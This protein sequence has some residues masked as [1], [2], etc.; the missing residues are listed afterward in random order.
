MT[1]D[2]PPWMG[3]VTAPFIPSL[4]EVQHHGAGDREVD[5]LVAA[6]A[7]TPDNP[8]RGDIKVCELLSCRC[9]LY[10]FVATSI[11]SE[12]FYFG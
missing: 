3:T 10:V 9:F 4:L 5:L 2:R 8:Q 11:F 1:A 7:V 6:L 12:A